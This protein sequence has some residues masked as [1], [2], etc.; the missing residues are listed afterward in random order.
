MKSNKGAALIFILVISLLIISLVTAIASQ[1]Q[2]EVGATQSIKSHKETKRI[3]DK[4]ES[5]LIFL[6]SNNMPNEVSSAEKVD[7]GLKPIDWNLSGKWVELTDNVQVSFTDEAGRVSIS[8]L[9]YVHLKTLLKGLG[10]PETRQN[11]IVDCIL[12]WT[13]RDDLKRLNGEESFY[14]KTLG[15]TGY[16]RNAYFESIDEVQHVCGVTEDIFNNLQN[17]LTMYRSDYLNL[18]AASEVFLT[19]MFGEESA[20][21][22]VEL[23]TQ[24]RLNRNTFL[25]TVI[26]AESEYTGLSFSPITRIKLKLKSGNIIVLRE[27]ILH[28][29]TTNVRPYQVYRIEV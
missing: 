10:L 20:K 26:F 15:K 27:F 9:N 28:R 14:Y 4:L 11:R 13:D 24:G 2:L 12:D 16:P 19:G 8:P 1:V 18:L 22:L 6:M 25:N 17:E 29:Q 7:L 23:R 5:K 21:K 3:L